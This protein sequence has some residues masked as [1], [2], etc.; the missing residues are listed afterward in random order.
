MFKH[1]LVPL[2][3]SLRAEAAISHAVAFARVFGSQIALVRV[4]AQAERTSLPLLIDPLEWQMSKRSMLDYL[5]EWAVRL[6]ALGVPTSHHLL[7]GSPAE[8]VIR[9]AAENAIDLIVLNRH[10]SN[11]SQGWPLGSVCHKIL[12]RSYTSTLLVQ[13]GNESTIPTHLRYE[14]IVAP[15][16]GSRRAECALMPTKA[17]MRTHGAKLMLAHVARKPEMFQA[18][19]FSLRESRMLAQHIYQRNRQEAHKYLH[20]MCERLSPD[21]AEVHL[22]VSDN[23]PTC[24]Q[25]MIQRQR[26][27]LVIMS[28]HGQLG[29]PWRP[30][31]PVAGSLIDSCSAPLLLVQDLSPARA[32]PREIMPK[33]YKGDDHCPKGTLGT[34]PQRLQRF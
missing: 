15:L 8:R 27:D 20:Q 1:I 26:A 33:S 5:G 32:P 14:R 10:G 16:D 13:A 2:D 11:G 23:V 17:L 3:G 24:L 25:G 21:R 28:A 30:F 29:A 31:G 9:F 19:T 22:L 34:A 7:E 12:L 18:P 4:A 6:R